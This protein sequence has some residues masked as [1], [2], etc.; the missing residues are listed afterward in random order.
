MNNFLPPTSNP[1]PEASISENKVLVEIRKWVNNPEG[2][3]KANLI[4]IYASGSALALYCFV[5]ILTTFGTIESYNEAYDAYATTRQYSRS[6]DFI[7]SYDNFT[8]ISRLLAL[9][10]L[11]FVTAVIA[12]TY[13]SHKLVNP[14]SKQKRKWGLGWTVGSWFTPVGFF[15][16]PLLVNRETEGIV[17]SEKEQ[18]SLF[19]PAWFYAIWAAIIARRIADEM[20]LGDSDFAQTLY[21]Y[22][23]GDVLTIA[24]VVFAV[25]YF[26][27]ISASVYEKEDEIKSGEFKVGTIEQPSKANTSAANVAEVTEQLRALG[28]LLSEGLISEEE[29]TLK[30]TELLKRF[31]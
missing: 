31:S 1:Q 25:L 16:I 3:L 9:F 5:S 27:E 8:S 11:P 23:V 26:G 17:K 7:K 30:K 24:A 4:A 12:W 21:V 22:I 28:Q 14:L 13:S 15:F 19:G 29:F 2:P 18:K 6:Q 20:I 10:A